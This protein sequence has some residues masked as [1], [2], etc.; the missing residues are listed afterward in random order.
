MTPDLILFLAGLAGSIIGG[1]AANWW[2]NRRQ[3]RPHYGTFH[4]PRR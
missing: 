4:F 1:F 2:L 3:P